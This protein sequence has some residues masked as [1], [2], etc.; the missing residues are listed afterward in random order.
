MRKDQVPGGKADKVSE[1]KFDP[2]EIETGI[3]VE[4]EHTGDPK[5]AKEIAMDHLMEFPDYYTRLLKMEKEA[6]KELASIAAEL[7]K[8][9]KKSFVSEITSL[10]GPPSTRGLQGLQEDIRYGSKKT[11]I[12]RE[13]DRVKKK[14]RIEELEPTEEIIFSSR[15]KIGKKEK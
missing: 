9:G 10:F 2:K 6:E 12:Q 11:S 15:K 14:D 4:M 5:L 1:E 7:H 8:R 3:K 13:I